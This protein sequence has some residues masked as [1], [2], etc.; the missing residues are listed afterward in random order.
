MSINALPDPP[1]PTDSV[2]NFDAKAFEFLASL[3]TFRTQ[4][5][6]TADA[7]QT[8]ADVTASIAMNM[9]LPNYGGTSTTSLAIGTGARSFVTQS[10]KSWTVG[11][12][13]VVSNG[14]NYMKGVVTGYTGTALDVN[15]TYAVGSGTFVSWTIGLSYAALGISPRAA[16]VDV[17]SVAGVVDLTANAPDTDDIQFTGNNAMTGFTAAVGRVFRFVVATG[18]TPSF[19]NGASLITQRG[20]NVQLA[21]GDSGELRVLAGGVVELLNFSSTA[22]AVQVPLRQT[23]LAG[24][25][26]FVAIG[27]GLACNLVAT[28]TPLRLAFANGMGAAGAS[29]FVGTLSADVTGYWSGLTANVVN[30]L[31]VDRNASTGALTAI[32][33]TL[34]YIAQDSVP[35]IS[36]VNGQHTYVSDVGQMYV[37]NGST[38]TAVQRDAVGECLAGASTIT[39]VV[40]YTKVGRYSNEQTTI[41]VATAYSFNSNIGTPFQRAIAW[42]ECKTAD[43]G[44]AVGDRIYVL[45]ADANGS[46]Y[47]GAAFWTTRNTCGFTF[48]GSGPKLPHKSTG[49][50]TD[51]V[52]GSW[53]VGFSVARGF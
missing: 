19:V 34:P 50:I 1:S 43:V 41:A 8:N 15:V 37:G 6:S 27:P 5:N 51:T 53:K 9:A 24:A 26:A 35:A 45:G 2:S 33:S 47:S 22:L 28:A 12:T 31:F 11:Q 21:G 36:V 52:I 32:S 38:A 13:V 49:T 16:R 29:D 46:V 20:A 4:A 40:S 48:G 44:Y 25:S 17:A 23:I 39:S 14:A 10:G 18:A 30:Y 3:Q 7:M 42:I